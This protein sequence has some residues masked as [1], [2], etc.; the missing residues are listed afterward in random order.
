LLRQTL[1][2]SRFH[3]QPRKD[4][5]QRLQARRRWRCTAL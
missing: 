4:R 5:S 2:E 1:H 3:R